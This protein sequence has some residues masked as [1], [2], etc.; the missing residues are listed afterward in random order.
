M[1]MVTATV[2]PGSENE[3]LATFR[4]VTHELPSEVVQT[5]LLRGE[6]NDWSVASVW[7][8]RAHLEQYLR[9]VDTQGAIELLRT[10]GGNPRRA[11]FDVL[12]E[13]HQTSS[14]SDPSP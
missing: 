3:V 1:T 14:M 12:H 13:S 6:A 11:T 9:H 8:S 7:R 2:P 10:A 5:F 4:L